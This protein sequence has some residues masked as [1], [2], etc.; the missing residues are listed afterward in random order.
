[1]QVRQFPT[2]KWRF[3]PFLNAA[4]L[5]HF[6]FL[7]S[8]NL[9]F[10]SEILAKIGLDQLQQLIGVDAEDQLILNHELL[11]EEAFLKEFYV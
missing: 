8:K 5:L 6:L 7:L 3:R 11:A 9:I 4:R 2:P 1:M 10:A